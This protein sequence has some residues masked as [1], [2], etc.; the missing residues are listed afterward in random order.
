MLNAI[1]LLR[2][3]PG[4]AALPAAPFLLPGAAAESGPFYFPILFGDWDRLFITTHAT[5]EHIRTLTAHFDA[6]YFDRRLLLAWDPAPSVDWWQPI[7][8][9]IH[10]FCY[11]EL[12][13]SLPLLR[14]AG[15]AS[16]RA[17]AQLIERHL[18]AAYPPF[19]GDKKDLS[20]TSKVLLS[21]G[22]TDLVVILAAGTYDGINQALSD[23]RRLTIDELASSSPEGQAI[24]ARCQD[25]ESG[26]ALPP[27]H[28]LFATTYSILGYAA[29]RSLADVHNDTAAILE[30]IDD[31]APCRARPT[32][33]L[34]TTP[35]H[36]P[37]LLSLLNNLELHIEAHVVPG[38]FDLQVTYEPTGGADSTQRSSLAWVLRALGALWSE[39]PALGLAGTNTVWRF[40]PET[41]ESGSPSLPS[42]AT[43]LLPFAI[44]PPFQRLDPGIVDFLGVERVD[45]FTT[46][47]ATYNLLVTHPFY[48]SYILDIGLFLERLIAVLPSAKT[49]ATRASD[50]SE[51][52]QLLYDVETLLRTGLFALSARATAGTHALRPDVLVSPGI[53]IQKVDRA[54]SALAEDLLVLVLGEDARQ[55]LSVLS[56]VV[57]VGDV[58]STC[59]AFPDGQTFILIEVPPT[60]VT[61]DRMLSF[62]HDVFHHAVPH[63]ESEYCDA[64]ADECAHWLADAICRGGLDTPAALEMLFPDFSALPAI[65]LAARFSSV[66]VSSARD[67]AAEQQRSLVAGIH[68][69][70]LANTRPAVLL[71][72]LATA[73]GR[74]PTAALDAF[75]ALDRIAADFD[76][77]LSRAL[78]TLEESAADALAVTVSGPVYRDHLSAH[79]PKP[80]LLEERL[81]LLD[82]LGTESS[83]PRVRYL[84]A[85]VCETEKRLAGHEKIRAFQS[86]CARF[87]QDRGGPPAGEFIEEILHCWSRG[88]RR[89]P[90]AVGSRARTSGTGDTRVSTTQDAQ[91]KG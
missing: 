65:S 23:L 44:P 51:Y 82:L 90:A 48:S 2:R 76:Y 75:A 11:I 74:E 7:C 53:G 49:L 31:V 30:S 27:H 59:L 41:A 50:H 22:Y 17:I 13:I 19:A 61:S 68:A 58:R 84:N 60:I 3:L 66:F 5:D 62:V 91:G 43:D 10:L 46:V 25:P 78:Q 55:R 16:L 56:V 15:Y 72:T 81:Y 47:V 14:A 32:I 26:Y 69:V 38:I 42:R 57:P 88:M 4:R 33:F 67:A 37:A 8:R 35:G 1:V 18:I 77:F 64:L 36:E 89:A 86:V 54:L 34:S 79:A 20:A 85:L 73:L 70:L 12:Q 39:G 21:L 28:P 63:R 87:T 6:Q 9:S 52:L 80:H 71:A 29:G 24:V 40:R 45:L 83:D